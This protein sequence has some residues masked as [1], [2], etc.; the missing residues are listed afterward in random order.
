MLVYS[1]MLALAQSSAAP[2]QALA[3]R[4]VGQFQM[5]YPFPS[6]N[7]ST[8]VFQGNFDGRWQLYEMKAADGTIRR[9]HVSP[10]DDTH[11]A[12]S[13]DGRQLA[14]I[15][16]RDGNDDVWLLDLASGAARVVAPH[17]GKDG[18]PKWSPDGRRLLFN[19]TFDPNDKGGDS[20]S[21][22]VQ[23]AVAS[24]PV[25]VLSDTPYVETFASYSPDGR[26]IAFV[27][28]FADAA[29]E[30][31][32]NGEIVVVD[33]STKARRNVTNSPEFDAYP[34]WGAA[35]WIYFSTVFAAPT[36]R[37]AVLSRVRGEGGPVERIGAVDG[38][39]EMRGIPTADGRSVWFNRM[40]GGRV[41]IF[42]QE[43][44]LTPP[45]TED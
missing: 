31:N 11:P 23:V 33:L 14:F 18:H 10:K 4:T 24:G 8:V 37:E 27:E 2:P 40:E 34:F 15:S 12:L 7:G 44:P 17:P 1:L 29:G 42:R 6:A 41:L 9:L 38:A 28:W 20:D 26:S 36:G 13:P 35:G 45:Q 19:R 43:L 5:A 25:E 22:I 32:R 16:N 21:A 30:R 3:P 39:S